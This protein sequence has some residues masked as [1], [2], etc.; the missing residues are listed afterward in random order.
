MQNRI[1]DLKVIMLAGLT[2]FGAFSFL[3]FGD[4][5]EEHILFLSY[6]RLTFLVH[7]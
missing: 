2:N 7:Y 1:S 3:P 4:F 5:S 6:T